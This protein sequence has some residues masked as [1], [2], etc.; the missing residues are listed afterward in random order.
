MGCSQE[1]IRIVHFLIHICNLSL[2]FMYLFGVQNIVVTVV[3]C[4]TL[5]SLVL[6]KRCIMF[7]MEEYCSDNKRIKG[8]IIDSVVEKI[9]SEKPSDLRYDLQYAIKGESYDDA[10]K[11]L[12]KR[13]KYLVLN[14]INFKIL[15]FTI[16]PK[17]YQKYVLIPFILW[18]WFI[19]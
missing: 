11:V 16:V 18:V 8:D 6:F 17:C 9:T 14:T 13:D 3:V 7:D 19:L 12:K 2:P 10:H 4:L 15:F 5:A 1:F